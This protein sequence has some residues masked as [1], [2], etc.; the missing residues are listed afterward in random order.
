MGQ[1]YLSYL[2]VYNEQIRDLLRPTPGVQL[3]L[4]EDK[5]QVHVA[6]LSEIRATS[7]HEVSKSR[8]GQLYKVLRVSTCTR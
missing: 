3:D 5:D 7:T 1:V 4:R 8:A 6:G 2:E